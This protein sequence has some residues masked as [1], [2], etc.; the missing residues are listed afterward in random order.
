MKSDT[1]SNNPSVLVVIVRAGPKTYA[2][3][4]YPKFV[5]KLDYS[6]MDVLLVNEE[7]CS[8]LKDEQIG[9]MIAYKGRHFGIKQ[10]INGHYDYVYFQDLDLE[11]D[12]GLLT[13]LVDS[14]HP[15]I[16]SLVAGRGDPYLIIG[17]NYQNREYQIRSPLY[18]SDLVDGQE[19]DGL[20]SCSLLIHKSIFEKLDY[21]GYKGPNHYPGRFCADDEYLCR[22]VYDQL[23][24]KPRII[25]EPRSWHYSSDGF[26]YRLLGK[27]E[28]FKLGVR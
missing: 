14:G 24:I 11:P 19:V 13:A 21:S 2:Y 6:N 1:V 25:L 17:H 23:K 16:G 8:E 22:C 12:K 9:E 5:K 20:G 28:S 10:A 4:F 3:D 15:F 18:L 26:K 7:N 27:K